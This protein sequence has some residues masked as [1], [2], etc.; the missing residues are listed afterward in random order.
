MLFEEYK[1]SDGIG[2]LD[3]VVLEK[4]KGPFTVPLSS[5]SS[6]CTIVVSG[7]LHGFLW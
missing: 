5:A 1:D 6:P 7:I 2:L 3:C 4:M